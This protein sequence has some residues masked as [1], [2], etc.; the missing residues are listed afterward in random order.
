MIQF[1]SIINISYHIHLNNALFT[2]LVVKFSYYDILNYSQ[3]KVPYFLT[4]VL[5]YK[6]D[7]ADKASSLALV[8]G[9]LS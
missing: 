8:S 7:K 5:L 1:I 3:T 9:A 6:T 4:L 2:K